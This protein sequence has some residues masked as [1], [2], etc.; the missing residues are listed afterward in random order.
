MEQNL[1]VKIEQPIFTPMTV[2]GVRT[3]MEKMPEDARK[4]SEFLI[5]FLKENRQN[6]DIMIGDSTQPGALLAGEAA[7]IPTAVVITAFPGGVEN[8]IDKLG[9]QSFYYL[10]VSWLV[11]PESNFRHKMQ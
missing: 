4:I 3:I 2:Q 8:V 6:F 1:A 5:P 11:F 9:T 10:V 7:N